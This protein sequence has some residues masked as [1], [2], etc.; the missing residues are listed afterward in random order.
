VRKLEHSWRQEPAVVKQ[1]SLKFF[2]HIQPFDTIP[3]Q[4]PISAGGHI[5]VTIPFSWCKK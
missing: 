5:Y 1:E 3:S 4:L 2:A